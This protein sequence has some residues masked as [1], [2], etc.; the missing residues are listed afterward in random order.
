MHNPGEKNNDHNHMESSQLLRN[1][2]CSKSINIEYEPLHRTHS[3]TNSR[4]PSRIGWKT[5]VVHAD[6]VKLRIARKSQVF[7]K[8]NSLKIAP[9]PSDYPD[10][11]PSDFSF[12][13]YKILFERSF[14]QFGKRDPFHNS[15]DVQRN[16]IIYFADYN[17]RLIGEANLSGY[18]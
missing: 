17:W 5:F 11:T 8:A 4:V 14:V 18:T 15:R 16:H 3:A 7:G 6:N 9:H 12:R 10:L 2:R 1:R 13:F